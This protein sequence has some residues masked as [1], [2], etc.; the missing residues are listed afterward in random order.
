MKGNAVW[1]F[2]DDTMTGHRVNNKS[3]IDYLLDEN[4]DDTRLTRGVIRKIRYE[5][6][7]ALCKCQWKLADESETPALDALSGELQKLSLDMNLPMSSGGNHEHLP[8][9]TMDADRLVD[10]SEAKNIPTSGATVDATKPTEN[11][12]P[13]LSAD[14][15]VFVPKLSADANSFTPKQSPNPLMLGH[16]G[17]IADSIHRPIGEINEVGEDRSMLS[18]SANPF[19]PGS[20]DCEIASDT[21]ENNGVVM[22]SVD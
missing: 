9:F 18:A 13:V 11:V 4:R 10:S 19:V 14:A 20:V 15:N 21:T 12:L 3:F 7:S 8:V 5:M 2:I 6:G 22:Q 1:R 17:S 16:P